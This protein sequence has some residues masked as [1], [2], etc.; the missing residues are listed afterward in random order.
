MRIFIAIP[1]P[2]VAKDKLAELKQS[3]EGVR[4]QQKEQI[5]LTLK[6]L[7]ETDLQRVKELQA[8]LDK[9]KHPPFTMTLRGFGCFPKGKYPRI[10]W[11]GISENPAVVGLHQKVEEVCT[12]MGFDAVDHSF[13][14]HVTLARMK[15]VS[16]KDIIPLI[17]Q[18]QEFRIS[19]LRISKF[20]LY[21]STLDTNGATHNPVK[22]FNLENGES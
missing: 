13:K 4:W 18:H 19:D 6:F 11:I 22:K 3:I 7:G 5:H 1:I 17:N 16:M 21:E 2:Q 14:P 15:G 10:F 9:I 12:S 20:V 8:Q